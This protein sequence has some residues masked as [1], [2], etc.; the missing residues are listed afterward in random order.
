[1]IKQIAILLVLL[2][3]K[4]LAQNNNYPQNYFRNP[5]N[6]PILLAGNFGEC[7]PGHF[8]SGIDIR[9][10]GKENLPV[11]AAADGYISRVKMEPG[12]FGHGIYITHL[13]GYTTLYAHLNDFFPA[14]QKCVRQEQYAQKSWTIDLSFD[15]QKFPIKKGQQIAW[16][17]NTGGSSAPHL[18]FEI[19][20]GKTE[21]PLNPQLF[22]FEIEDT[23]SPLPTEIAI[24][25]GTESIYLQNPTRVP[26]KKLQDIFVPIK[27]SI[28]V[29][30]DAISLGVAVNDYMNN[31]TNTLSFYTAQWYAN[32]VLVGSIRLDDIGYNETRYLNACADYKLQ[33]ETGIWFN[34]LFLLPNNQLHKLYQFEQ[35]GNGQIVLN[36][37]APTP[38]RIVLTDV[39]G[40]ASEIKFMII[41][42]EKTTP[43]LCSQTWKS[44]QEHNFETPNLKF[45]LPA[46]A[47]Y[48]DIC[49]ETSK[50]TE[51]KS[52][53][54]RFSIVTPAIPI[55]NYFD[56]SI[57]PEVAIPFA[58]ISKMTLQYSDSKKISGKKASLT[59][60]WYGAS[61][62]AFG[63]YW[64]AI[65]TTA[66]LIKPVDKN[67]VLLGLGKEI[68]F[69]VTDNLS[70]VKSFTGSIN[71][72]WICFEQ[73]GDNWFYL[74]DEHCPKGKNKL[75]LSAIDENG[76]ERKMQFDCTRL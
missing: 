48:D 70:S 34:S 8:H 40:N 35:K 60:G 6:I 64:L 14:L 51:A 26:L 43:S 19:R 21:H 2:P 73:H 7:R 31:S 38:I 55:H 74:I 76:N 56:L 41:R 5:L 25:N 45:T 13:N 27:D 69:V 44:K 62:R 59:N 33:K 1:M 29:S 12:G 50:N 3:F 68:R 28:M 4:S 10:E 58:L 49:F 65:D 61:V 53:S 47:L 18:H 11:F 23:V 66:P 54:S 71:G 72:Q 17:G 39:S 22:G 32:N 57:K 20:D 75:H 16:S 63:D 67:G 36:K 46:T 42:A 52:S 30:A 37:L 15:A 9:T 24:Y